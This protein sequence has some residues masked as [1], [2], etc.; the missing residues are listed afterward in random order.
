MG[1]I[2]STLVGHEMWF[3]LPLAAFTFAETQTMCARPSLSVRSSAPLAQ[4]SLVIHNLGGQATAGLWVGFAVESNE[5][6]RKH[7]PT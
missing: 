2:A 4:I 6:I 7:W 5:H 3:A 1:A